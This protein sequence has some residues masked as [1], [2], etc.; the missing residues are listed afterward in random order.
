MVNTVGALVTANAVVF[1]AAA[2][3]RRNTIDV[4]ILGITTAIALTTID[5]V[6]VSR[7][8]ISAVYLVDAAA[9]VV[10]IALWAVVL[11]RDKTWAI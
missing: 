3:S 6:Y 5:V 10:L 7:G 4:A 1:L 2:W 11:W 8:T 9:E